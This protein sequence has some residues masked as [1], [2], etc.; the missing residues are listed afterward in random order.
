MN[1]ITYNK[2]TSY[3]HDDLLWMSNH[4][5]QDVSVCLFFLHTILCTLFVHVV[6]GAREIS[7]MLYNL[8]VQ[9]S[10][11]ILLLTNYN[12][13]AH[14]FLKIHVILVNGKGSAIPKPRRNI[15]FIQLDEH[16]CNSK[17]II[18]STTYWSQTH[19]PF[20]TQWHQD[21]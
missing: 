15:P 2:E 21:K 13:K 6:R 17:R 1:R 20:H 9:R 18:R 10:T 8:R 12:Q 11:G 4:N 5:S 19:K 14:N 3:S 16:K 7:F